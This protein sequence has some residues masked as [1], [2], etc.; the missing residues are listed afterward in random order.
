MYRVYGRRLRCLAAFC[1]VACFAGKL[2]IAQSP[3]DSASQSPPNIQINIQII[4]VDTRA[5]A[6]RIHDQLEK[7]ADFSATAKAQSLDPTAASGGYLGATDVNTLR[8]ELQE[9]LKAV[10]PG[11][12][13]SVVKIPT[14]YAILRIVPQQAEPSSGDIWVNGSKDLPLT[15]HAVI[16][17]PPN[18]AGVPD[19]ELIFHSISKP[20][21]WNSD[22]RYVCE[23]H[24]DSTNTAIQTLRGMVSPTGLAANP[25][26]PSDLLN[27][28]Y[29]LAALES[30]QGK[31]DA[32]IADW[33][34]A[35]AVAEK[36]Q[37]TA[38]TTFT[39][40]LGTAYYHKS[41]VENDVYSRPG[42]RCLFP[43]RTDKP[44]PAYTK[45]ADSQK[46]IE[47][48]DEYLAK[49]PDD[50]EVKW[51]LNLAYMTLG[52]YPKAVPAK[53]LIPPSAFASKENI[54]RFTD[55]A[56]QAGL[57]IATLSGGILVGDFENNGLLDIV[58]GDYDACDTVHYFHN[59]G[60]GTFSD[61]TQQAGL[62]GVV[63][64]Q[65]MIQAD[66]NN[67]G[68]TDILIMRGAWQFPMPLTLLKNN[69]DGTF[70]DVTKE[71]GLGDRLFAT[72]AGVF[73]DVNNDG[74]VDLFLGN[75]QGP[76]AL[77]LNKGDGTFE[78]ISHSSGVDSISSSFTK[79]V[80]AADYD[81]DGYPDFFLSNITGNNILF[82]NNG[83][84][85]FTDVAAKAGVQKSWSS[86]TTWFF[87]YDNDG[88]PDLFV[89]SYYASVDETMRSYLGLPRSV[90][91]LTL[92]KNMGDGTFKDVT[93]QVGLDKSFMTMGAS[94][95]DAD[96]DGW[97]DMYLGN[98]AAD[99]GALVPKTLLRNDEGKHFTDITT[100]SGT[101]DLHPAHGIVFADFANNGQ[102]D[103]AMAVGGAAV[104]NW[105]AMRLFRNPGHSNDWITLKLVGVK[106]NR[107]AIGARVKVTVSDKGA[108]PRSIYRTVGSFSSFASGPL[109]LEIGLGKDAKI[110]SIDVYWPTSR[111]HQIFKDVGVDQFLEI[112][113]SKPVYKKLDYQPFRLKGVEE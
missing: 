53:Y 46:A 29:S 84:L 87:D 88:W 10:P 45:T 9:A 70:T 54:G 44:Y 71:A 98:G 7:G 11:Q 34:K 109:R 15:G 81:H 39:E 13:T 68:C 14:G 49:N 21:G 41:E 86:Y 6:E 30:Y 24:R 51:L 16:R 64:G 105:H 73:A 61:R 78:D 97:L 79:G 113:E 5:A 63:S 96:N 85:T 77:F 4:V 32:A 33:Q 42:D 75:E 111:T 100:S 52:E 43:P 112:T 92:Y 66:Y 72:Q 90:G 40:V 65:N 93:S 80:V 18:T 25:M 58:V 31:M 104:S 56:P 103:I 59:N 106:T 47:Y 89:A 48:F 20:K 2:L 102:Q 1:F 82:H 108:A 60:D 23:L 50:L 107:S 38:L 3:S 101:G 19:V 12:I 17:Y 27:A 91:Q 76:S 28:L 8:P 37:P 95:G 74:N 110:L 35:Y 55:V 62:S 57:D 83:D 69:C 94:F 36:S 22:P 67:D 26:S 99:W